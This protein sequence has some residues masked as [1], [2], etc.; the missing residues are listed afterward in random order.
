MLFFQDNPA[1][2][3]P[4]QVD[5]PAPP[6]TTTAAT[7]V[8]PVGATQLNVPAV[9]NVAHVTTAAVM[10]FDAALHAPKPVAF[11]AF[12]LNVYDVPVVRPVTVNGEAAPDAVTQ[13]GVDVAV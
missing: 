10:L 8:T 1:P 2:P 5:P 3:P 7:L 4:R 9:V 6:P 11:C 12:T 13:P